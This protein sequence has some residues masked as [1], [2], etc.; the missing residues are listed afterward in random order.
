M[1]S[2]LFRRRVLAVRLQVSKRL[3]VRNVVVFTAFLKDVCH[4][5]AP[6][7]GLSVMMMTVL[8]R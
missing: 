7:G 1:G 3:L 8:F 2:I 4:G 5:L 6:G